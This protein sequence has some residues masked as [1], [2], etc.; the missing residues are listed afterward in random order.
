[1]EVDYNLTKKEFQKE[2][3]TYMKSVTDG[4][5]EICSYIGAEGVIIKEGDKVSIMTY[6]YKEHLFDFEFKL[7]D[8]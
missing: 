8:I 5:A 3:E 2:Y 7:R 4:F 1:M 6:Q